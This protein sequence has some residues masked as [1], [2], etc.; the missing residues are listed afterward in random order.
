MFTSYRVGGVTVPGS[1]PT[2]GIS[3]GAQDY[4]R[5][6]DATPTPLVV[7]EC[8]S[9]HIATVNASAMRILGF[10]KAELR[11]LYLLDFLDEADRATVQK[12]KGLLEPQ[13][14]WD[15]ARRDGKALRM[16]AAG[17][18]PFHFQGK[19]CFLLYGPAAAA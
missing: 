14:T 13:S 1:L 12:A 17:G 7:V 19:E 5:V 10:S 9:L 4:L 16:L 15:L 11:A 2:A 8:D 6:F 18:R 3:D